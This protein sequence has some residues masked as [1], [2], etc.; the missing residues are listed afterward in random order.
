M[1]SEIQGVNIVL[2]GDF[3]PAIFHP[4]WFAYYELIRR[5]EAEAAKIQVIHPD[6]AVFSTEWL[7]FNVGRDRFQAATALES[8]YESIRDLVL[9]VLSL[10]SHTP[11]RV[12][13]INRNFHYRHRSLEA[14]HSV[15]HQLVPKQYWERLLDNPGM[16]NLTV[17]GT[18]PDGLPGYIQVRVAPST[19]IEH[20]IYVSINDHYVLNAEQIS[21]ASSEA[22][23]ILNEIWGVSI[24]RSLAIANAISKLE[25]DQ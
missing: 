14:W 18:R 7:D 20:G 22:I 24:E 4:S 11:L 12:M 25:S 13:G 21:S 15:G 17:E 8:H 3:N 5:E 2:R 6:V 1:D 10:L 23:R 9:S 19:R 16:R